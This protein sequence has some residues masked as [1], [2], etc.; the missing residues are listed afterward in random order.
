M[1]TAGGNYLGWRRE[2]EDEEG[3]KIDPKR[4]FNKTNKVFNQYL[5]LKKDELEG[6]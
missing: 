4:S 6:E 2:S 1:K 3:E 5:Y